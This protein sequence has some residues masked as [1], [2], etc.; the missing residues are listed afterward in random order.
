MWEI[1]AA[2]RVVGVSRYA[3][4]LDGAEDRVN[5]S[6]GAGP[7]V[8]KVVGAEPDLVLVPNSTHAF[9]PGRVQQIRDAGIPVFVFGTGTSL[10]FVADKTELTGRLVGECDAGRARANEMRESI[11]DIE[12]AL[13]GEQTPVGLNYFFG[14]TSGENTFIGN[15]M[16][17]AGLE[18]GAADVGITGFR[19]I[20]EE[21]VVAMNPSWIVI[22]SDASVPDSAG[23]RSTAAVHRDQ[24][25]SVDSNHLQQP[26]PR[27]V[28]A[29]E[30]IMER[31]H[32]DAYR[33]YETGTD[34]NGSG[35]DANN[36]R[37]SRSGDDD[38][39]SSD[40]AES[41]PTA[42]TDRADRTQLRTTGNATLVLSDPEA[43]GVIG[44]KVENA[45]TEETVTIDVANGTSRNRTPTSGWAI[46]RL[47][48][49]F[50]NETDTIIRIHPSDT[51][52]VGT[53]V[54][55]TSFAEPTE[56]ASVIGYLNVSHTASGGRISSAEIVVRVNQTV[57]E[58]QKSNEI[59][60]YRGHGETW[61]RLKTTALGDGRFAARTPGFS[62]FAIVGVG[63]NSDQ[64][65][66]TATSTT[67]EPAETTS[68]TE[69]AETVS[70]AT[71]PP[72]RTPTRT[73]DR[74]QTTREETTE[75]EGPGF[76]LGATVIALAL[77][78]AL[79]TRRA[80]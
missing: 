26:A 2:D 28:R 1:G 67:T 59:V 72:E 12:A 10:E 43:N 51:T 30:T 4:Y 41:T 14:F 47:D 20:N 11:D 36:D 53:R 75:A 80:D 58:N 39:T 71:V 16:L 35:S 21:T 79:V 31:V 74:R 61:T 77:L 68:T 29:V 42:G 46:E 15:V 63:V 45:S 38:S 57:L 7:N 60:L 22:P 65:V 23:Y 50:S 56:N 49:T 64:V 40:A 33:E 69:P 78:T 66:A 62:T 76:G 13:V 52:S 5:V 17:T 73:A 24:V 27:V 19:R 55:N 8:E 3:T 18:N 6:G 34:P 9:A 32:P 70:T 54:T 25:I 44:V 37:D 48:V